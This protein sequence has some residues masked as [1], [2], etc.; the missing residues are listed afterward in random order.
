MLGY[1]RDNTQIL[2]NAIKYLESQYN[3]DSVIQEEE[4]KD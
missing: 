1:A 3:W 4:W 2:L